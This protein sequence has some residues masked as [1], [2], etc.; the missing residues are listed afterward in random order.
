MSEKVV[1]DGRI[2]FYFHYKYDQN[3][4]HE[5][6]DEV[7]AMTCQKYNT[8]ILFIPQKINLKI[9]FIKN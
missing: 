4:S 5:L 9:F 6:H 1:I 8:N 2:L 7:I 3:P